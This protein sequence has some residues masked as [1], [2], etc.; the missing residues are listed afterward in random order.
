MKVLRMKNLG[1]GTIETPEGKKEVYRTSF[2]CED[3]KEY[4][5]DC[6]ATID[7]APNPARARMDY[8]RDYL[9]TVGVS[10]AEFDDVLGALISAGQKPKLNGG[11]IHGSR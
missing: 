9:E 2:L 4:N 1:R 3:G 6:P 10:H 5:S 11:S 7:F 8:D